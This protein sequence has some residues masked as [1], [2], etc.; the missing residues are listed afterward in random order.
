MKEKDFQKWVVDTAQSFGWR[1]WHTPTPMKPVG[2]NKFVPDRRGRGLP[3][4][5]MMHDDPPRLIFAELKKI[6]GDVSDAQVEFLKL[7]RAVAEATG[8]VVGS[9][10]TVGVYMWR[11]GAEEIIESILRSKVMV[12]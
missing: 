9:G 6:G 3:D 5:V 12:A 4:L 8:I 10:R 11:P 2:G 7:A 1:V